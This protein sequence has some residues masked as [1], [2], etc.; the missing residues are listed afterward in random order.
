MTM[1]TRDI[2]GALAHIDRMRKAARNDYERTMRKLDNDER[3]LL[4]L[5]RAADCESEASK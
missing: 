1:S 5:K 2:D 4:G 3:D